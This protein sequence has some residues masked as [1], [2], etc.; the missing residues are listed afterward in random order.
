[1]T[2]PL[3]TFIQ[4]RNP[5]AL[6]RFEF[7]YKISGEEADIIFEDVLRYLWLTAS[8][9]DRRKSDPDTP[10]ITIW[11]GMVVIDEMWHCF[12]LVTEQYTDFCEQ[13]FGRYIHHPPPLFKYLNNVKELGEEHGDEILVEELIPLVYEELGEDVAIRW[14]DTYL[15]YTEMRNIH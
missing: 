3:A 5:E 4:Y 12:I 14:F 11:N 15:Q 8:L 13:N 7:E 10:D 9:E 6:R 1:M 2:Q